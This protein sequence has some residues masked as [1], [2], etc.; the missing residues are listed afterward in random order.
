MISLIAATLFT[1][2]TTTAAVRFDKKFEVANVRGVAVCPGPGST[3]FVAGED[4]TIWHVN[5]ATGAKLRKFSGHPQSVYGLCAN[6]TGTILASGDESGRIWFWNVKTGAKVKEFARTKDTHARGIQAISFSADGK[7]V[8]TTGK[9]DQ[10]IV[11]DYARSAIVK[12]LPSNGANVSSATL[13][14]TGM[15]AITLGGGLWQ[16]K[17]GA[18]ASRLPAHGGQGGMDFK[19]DTGG[20][21]G[22]SGGRDGSVILWNLKTKQPIS[23]NAAHEDSVISVAMSP[24]GK[25]AASSCSVDRSVKLWDVSSGGLIK[26]LSEQSAVGAPLCFTMDGKY[27]VSSSAG[28]QPVVYSVTPAQGAGKAKK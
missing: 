2:A 4:N 5:A 26:T 7:T 18:L 25:V 16:Y 19:A 13:T 17:A 14:S 1:P 11:W 15:W 22:I 23:K 3:F 21:R 27:F 24:N 10:I 8:A 9:D 6:P 20:T 12:K 28:D